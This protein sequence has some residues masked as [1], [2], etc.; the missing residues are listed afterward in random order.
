MIEMKKIKV[1]TKNVDKILKKL[2]RICNRY[3]IA[4]I[5]KNVGQKD[6]SV[7]YIGPFRVYRTVRRN[8]SK[9]GEYKTK[10]KCWFKSSAYGV[11]YH[12]FFKHPE[13]IPYTLREDDNKPLIFI[14]TGV[15]SA[16]VI[17]DDSYIRFL[18][19]GIFVIYD[20]NFI[21][22]GISDALYIHICFPVWF[23]KIKNMEEVLQNRSKEEIALE[24][25]RYRGEM[26]CEDFEEEDD[27]Y[28]GDEEDL[29]W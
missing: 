15:D 12:R 28:W 24:E 27:Y 16:N 25:R 18:P 10:I 22:S 9:N 26:E 6:H 17:Y 1:T 11:D 21:N 4:E 3:E 29:Y 8:L 5:R 20:Y 19:F 2:Q 14:D 13:E 23:R 7:S